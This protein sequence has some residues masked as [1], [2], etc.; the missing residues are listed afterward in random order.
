MVLITY[1]PGQQSGLPQRE[2]SG[3]ATVIIKNKYWTPPNTSSSQH[4]GLIA[5]KHKLKAQ[6]EGITEPFQHNTLLSI[7]PWYSAFKVSVIQSKVLLKG[8]LIYSLKD[9]GISA[10]VWLAQRQKYKS[11]S[12]CFF[13]T[14]EVIL[15]PL[16]PHCRPSFLFLACARMFSLST[17]LNWQNANSTQFTAAP[18]KNNHHLVAASSCWG[19]LMKHPHTFP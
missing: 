11:R 14:V 10:T 18:Q 2:K 7:P 5:L 13:Y 17:W 6:K 4:S 15:E 12:H 8:G 3:L 9:M 19:C 16:A 1:I